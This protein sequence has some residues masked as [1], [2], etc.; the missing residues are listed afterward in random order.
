MIVIARNTEHKLYQELK[1]CKKKTV[2][3]RCFYIALS[4]VD[5]P[6]KEK[7]ETL[8][9]TLQDIPDSYMAQ[10][11]MCHDQDVFI[12]MAGFMQRQFNDFLQGLS[13]DLNMPELLSQASIFDIHDHWEDLEK[14]C[15]EKMELN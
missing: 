15:Q 6:R 1:N 13:K 4:R 2:S 10:I 8:L 14:L 7:F 9:S 12:L 11:Y 5:L 3:Q